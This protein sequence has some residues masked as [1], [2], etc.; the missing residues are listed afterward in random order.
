MG[1][2]EIRRES[3]Q[4]IA[5]FCHHYAKRVTEVS[6]S[7]EIW[8]PQ[9]DS[10]RLQVSAIPYESVVSVEEFTWFER[11][12]V[13]ERHR[14]NVHKVGVRLRV[15]EQARRAERTERID[16]RL[17]ASARVRICPDRAVDVGETIGIDRDP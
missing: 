13:V 2:D 6:R 17:P 4:M 7:S 16:D 12:P 5:F 11:F 15:V 9:T 14:H 1:A 3:D 10:L 8:G